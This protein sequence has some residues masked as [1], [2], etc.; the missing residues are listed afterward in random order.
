MNKKLDESSTEISSG[1]TLPEAK[2]ILLKAMHDK[3]LANV[4]MPKRWSYEGVVTPVNEKV[5]IY[6]YKSKIN[7]WLNCFIHNIFK[8]V[9]VYLIRLCFHSHICK[10]KAV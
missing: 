10:I 4:S 5:E 7:G 3:L 9:S 8:R 2:E 6:I 1:S